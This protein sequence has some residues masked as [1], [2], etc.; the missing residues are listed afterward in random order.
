MGTAPEAP[1]ADSAMTYYTV[2]IRE[3]M[4]TL[5]ECQKPDIYWE[6]ETDYRTVFRTGE[7]TALIR[8]CGGYSVSARLLEENLTVTPDWVVR[9]DPGVIVK[10]T[11][12][13]TLGRGVLTPGGA[14]ALR[15]AIC[16]RPD[17]AGI[18]AVRNGRVV[19]I[20]RQLLTTPARRTA[21]ILYIAKAAMPQLMEDV[22]PDEAFRALAEEENGTV[23]EGVYALWQ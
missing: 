11:D 17:W 14:V 7:E 10:V 9:K 4:G 12:D 23:P 19:L 21:A 18:Q 1:D 5:F 15:S 16:A 6:T 8:P 22:D 20:S 2:L 13:R 3:R